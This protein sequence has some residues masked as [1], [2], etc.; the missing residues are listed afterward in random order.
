VR[1]LATAEPHLYLDLVTFLEEASSRS[2]A[3]L[4]I[5]L[6]R[7]RSNAHLLD[8]GDV[9]VLLGIAGTLVLL[10]AKLA[11]VGDPADRRTGAPGDFD[12]VEAGLL[13]TL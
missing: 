2:D 10:E 6:V 4:Q 7:P 11:Q 8:L 12:Q 1:R 3:D 5:V 13:G 9:L